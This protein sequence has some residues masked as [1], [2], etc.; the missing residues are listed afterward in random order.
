MLH[1]CYIV[2]QTFA[3]YYARYITFVNATWNTIIHLKL[4]TRHVQTCTVFNYRR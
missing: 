1:R 3:I 4:A 2:G